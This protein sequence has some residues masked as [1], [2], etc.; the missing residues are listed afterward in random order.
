MRVFIAVLLVLS[1]TAHAQVPRHIS[2]QGVLADAQGNLV[3]DGNHELSLTLFDAATNGNALFTETQTVPVV[4]GIFNVIIGSVTVLPPSLSFDRAYF[5]GVR[6]NGGGELSPRTPLTAVPYALRAER[7]GVAE[8]LA[9]NASGAVTSI[10]NQSGSVTIQGG[11]GTTVT[12][13]G[14]VFTISSTGA[15]GT[16]IQGVQSTD[17]GIAITSPNGPVANL[18]IA[19]NAVTSSKIADGSITANDIAPGVLPSAADFITVG[20]SAGG[21]LNGTYPN[22]LIADGAVT[23]AKISDNAISNDKIA[24]GAVTSQNIAANQ[25]VKRLNGLTDD[26]ILAAGSN[27]TITPNGNAL[28]IASGGNSVQRIQNDNNT[29]DVINGD[30]P[31]TTVNLKA[32]GVNTAQLADGAVSAA[33]LAPGVLPLT[34]PPSG[35]AGGD[36]SGTYPNPTI[37]ANAVNSSRIA[38]GTVANADI[39]DNAVTITKIGDAGATNGQ[40]ITFNGSDVVWQ[41]PAGVGGSGAANR[42]AFWNGSSSLT[43]DANYT[44]TPGNNTK[45]ALGFQC[46]ATGDN[47]VAIGAQCSASGSNTVAIGA[48]STASANGAVAIGVNAIASGVR[49]H[50]IG[51]FVTASNGGSCVMGDNNTTTLSSSASNQMNMRFVGGYRL[52]SN[53]AFTTGVTMAAGVSGWTNICDRNLKRDFSPV[54]GEWLLGRIRELPI[55]EWSYI[56]SDPSIRYIGPM[57]QDFHAAFHLGGSDSL[58]INSIIADGV[59]LAAIK[60]LEERTRVLHE[61]VLA[62]QRLIDQLLDEQRTHGVRRASHRKD[63]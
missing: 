36:L 37:A 45:I 38:D 1:C 62:Q 34:L 40:V 35:S 29:I 49:A 18:G 26:V 59:N 57:A 61:T 9:P 39:A 42:V 33:K 31:I 14:A 23:T 8:A 55:T 56:K 7:A 60:A 63:S 15:G 48:G 16:G 11:G 25:V 43:S 17:G 51:N 30:G 54:D 44:I 50:A 6:V 22:P 24:G 53:S 58:G 5:L 52:F 12:N 13:N 21:D 3:P 46:T 47:G 41:T 20:G 32:N 28:T 19:A 10:N 4:N 27:I 2:Y